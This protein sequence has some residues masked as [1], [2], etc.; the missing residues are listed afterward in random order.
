MAT[1]FPL[2]INNLRFFVNPTQLSISNAVTYG[3]L[4]TQ[5]GV[6]YQVWYDTP[7]VLTISGASAGSTAYQELVFLKQNF[8][9][10]DKTSKLFY[11]TQLYTG[12]LT[13]ITVEASTSHPNEFT[14]TITFQLLQ[15]QQFSLEDFSL[16]ANQAGAVQNALNK[17]ASVINA[18][19]NSLESTA[20]KLLS[21]L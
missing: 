11:K 1:K 5:S 16:K 2:Q 6:R 9:R 17:L 19:L 13:N 12:F 18:P 20:Q 4:P 15:G 3:T 8:Q 10:S 21:K 7:P 14:Y